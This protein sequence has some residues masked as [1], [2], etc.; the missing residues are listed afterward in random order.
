MALRAEEPLVLTRMDADIPLACLSSG[1]AHQ[2][3]AEYGGGVYDDPP[4]FAWKT[5]QEEYVWTPIALQ[6]NLTTL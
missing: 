1:G 5:C 2:I 4:G 3:R 6:A